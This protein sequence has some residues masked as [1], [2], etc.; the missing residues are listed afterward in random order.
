MSIIFRL[1]L[2]KWIVFVLRNCYA[3]LRQKVIVRVNNR[4]LFRLWNRRSN[5]LNL[6]LLRFRKRLSNHRMWPELFQY[7][8]SLIL[9]SL[10]YIKNPRVFRQGLSEFLAAVR[11]NYV[12][13]CA[14]EYFAS[15]LEIYSLRLRS[16]SLFFFW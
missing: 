10:D 5:E 9:L 14:F 8:I 2:V 15:K 11:I 4:L 3:A 13:V 12:F 16:F 1:D 6:V 7:W